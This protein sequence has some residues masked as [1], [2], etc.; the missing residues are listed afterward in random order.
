MYVKCKVY[1]VMYMKQD[2]HISIVA[3]LPKVQHTM[4]S[5]W[6][7]MLSQAIKRVEQLKTGN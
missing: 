4:Y 7:I 1:F 3:T 5:T 2:L 6:R